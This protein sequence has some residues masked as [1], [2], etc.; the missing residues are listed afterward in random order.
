MVR[1]SLPLSAAQWHTLRLPCANLPG[2]AIGMGNS[3]SLPFYFFI[4]PVPSRTLRQSAAT[5]YTSCHNKSSAGRVN[6]APEVVKWLRVIA[7]SRHHMDPALSPNPTPTQR[8]ATKRQ[9]LFTV[10]A[11]SE[12]TLGNDRDS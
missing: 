10:P 2:Q 7:A 4:S 5:V 12:K 11:H 3:C 9:Y 1:Y 8:P 6:G